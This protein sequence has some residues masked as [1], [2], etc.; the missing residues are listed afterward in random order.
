M[1]YR[2]YYPFF[3]LLKS[4]FVLWKRYLLFLKKDTAGFEWLSYAR[5]YGTI[6]LKAKLAAIAR[7][8]EI[9]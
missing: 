2:L 8:Q 3:G 7:Y 5:K 9:I 4:T 6:R 1:Y